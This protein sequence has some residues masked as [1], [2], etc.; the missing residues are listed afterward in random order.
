M[1]HKSAQPVRQSGGQTSHYE[2][3]TTT[4]AYVERTLNDTCFTIIVI[5]DSDTDE[6]SVSYDGTTVEADLHPR[7]NITLQTNGK[8]SVY[9]IAETGGDKVRIWGY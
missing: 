7:E 8:G 4:N 2:E 5:N 3:Y 9:I 1:F 6:V